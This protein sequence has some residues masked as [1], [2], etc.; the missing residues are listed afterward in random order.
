MSWEDPV[1]N[2]PAVLRE[3]E[4]DR[5]IQLGNVAKTLD[6]MQSD[7]PRYALRFISGKYQGGEFPLRMNRE[8]IIG[9]SSDLDMVLVEDMVSRRHAKISTADG[10]VYI[11][12]MGSTNGTFV[13]GEKV[14]RSRLQEGD[15]ILVGTSI[16]KMVAV[17]AS[18]Y[19]EQSEAEAR[20]RLEAGAARQQTSG[21]PMSGVIEEIPLPDLLQL[22]STS[23]KSGVLTVTTTTAVGRIYLRQ[24]QLYFA[25]INDDFGASPHKAI[26]RMLTWVAGTF[27]LEPGGEI[28]VMEEIQESTEGILMEGM[29]Q[30]DEIRQLEEKLPPYHS[31]LAV[32]TPL[33]G[34]LRDLSPQELDIFQ[35]VLDHGQVQ[36]V[37]DYYYGTDLEA[38]QSLLGLMQREFIV[39]P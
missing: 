16:I 37:L 22:L 17:D 2:G 4:Q 1:G 11:E 35:L 8:I 7:R 12:D 38:A 21:R 23:R 13:N 29:R 26:F 5:K 20:R 30:L 33:A 10:E 32:P 31:A 27:E 36:A 34:K 19:A 18:S 24:G 3:M 14:S 25:A 39:V 6:N 15:R 28:R 9:R